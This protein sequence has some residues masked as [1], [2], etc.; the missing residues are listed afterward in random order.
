[1]PVEHTP[2]GIGEDIARNR[3]VD[4]ENQRLRESSAELLRELIN[5]RRRFHEACRYAGSDEEF[6]LLSTPTADSAIARATQ[7]T[8]HAG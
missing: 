3:R 6:V 5:L 2:E 4:A 8:P 7:E 1:M